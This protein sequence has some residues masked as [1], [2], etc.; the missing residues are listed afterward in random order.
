MTA[1]P[2]PP[3]DVVLG[4]PRRAALDAFAGQGW[5][6][7]ATPIGLD[8]ERRR[9]LNVDLSEPDV[10]FQH[11][12]DVAAVAHVETDR[13][14]L[15]THVEVVGVEPADPV[16]VALA[17]LGH[18]GPPRAE[19]GPDARAWVWG[20]E[21]GARAAIR[22]EPVRLWICAERAYGDRLWLVATLV[23]RG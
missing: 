7:W 16:Q 21:S 12:G 10:A 14:G 1:V 2:L 3:L 23:R 22:G 8:A 17:L 6:P 18:A 20:P 9:V 19:S 5:R 13:E 11:E 15:V 4:R